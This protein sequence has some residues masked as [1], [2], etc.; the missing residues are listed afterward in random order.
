MYP[1][2]LRIL[3]HTLLHDEQTIFQYS[4]EAKFIIF[5]L[6]VAQQLCQ[7]PRNDEDGEHR[8]QKLQWFVGT[9]S[10]SDFYGDIKHTLSTISLPDKIV[11]NKNERTGINL[12]TRNP[13][14]TQ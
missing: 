12:V 1:K 6:T 13:L 14:A 3:H 4:V 11:V 2:L 7:V 9:Y 5:F 8:L 10:A